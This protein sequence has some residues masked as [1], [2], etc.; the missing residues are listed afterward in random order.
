[1]AK[2][3]S[4]DSFV[5]AIHR[6]PLV[7]RIIAIARDKSDADASKATTATSRHPSIPK[8]E[9][10]LA[11]GTPRATLV[12]CRGDSAGNFVR[13][14]LASVGKRDFGMYPLRGKFLNARGLTSKSVLD[15]KEATELL[16]ILGIQLNTTYTRETA[17]KL[18]YARLMVAADQDVDGSHIAGLVFNFIDACAPSLLAVKPGYLC[19]F[20]TSLI[21]VSL[22]SGRRAEEIGFYSQ[23]EYDAWYNHQKEAG[24]SVGKPWYFKGLG[25]S[26]ASLAKEYFKDLRKEQHRDATHGIECSDAL[27]MAFHKKRTDDRK[28]FDDAVRSECLRAVRARGDDAHHIRARRVAAPVC[29]FDVASR[30]PGIGRI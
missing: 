12:V 13:S 25:T 29:S 14:G 18:P 23:I 4:S 7:D 3:V 22:G 8:Y 28:D 17:S 5:S 30:H 9:P 2:V 11:R 27:D 24:H 1:M 21:R 15:N 20:A 6:S 10:A 26:S 19:R 16:K